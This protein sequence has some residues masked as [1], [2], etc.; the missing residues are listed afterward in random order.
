MFQKKK[1]EK[2]TNGYSTVTVKNKRNKKN[3]KKNSSNN[4]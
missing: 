4:N 1:R 3:K 2:F